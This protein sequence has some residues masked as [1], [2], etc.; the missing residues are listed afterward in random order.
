MSNINLIIEER[1][2][3]IGKFLVGR[4]LPF[5]QKRM[6]GPFIYLD[7]MGP[8]KLNEREHFD[9]L[10]HPH[11]G[12]STLTFL[13]EGSIMH[14]DTLG[15]EVEIKP[16]AV[17]WMTAGKGIVHSERTPEYLRHED[18]VMHGLQIW[19]ALPK[20]LEQMNPEFF[21]IEAEKLPTWSI[22]EVDYKLIAGE[23]MGHRST[24]P[25]YSNLFLMEIKSRKRQ[26]LNL[27]NHLFGESGLYIMEGG[28]ESEG[29]SY[30]SKQILVAKDSTLCTFTIEAN[31]T[32]YIFG[33]EPFPEERFI[34]WNFVSSSKE[35][36]EE[37]KQK[38][39]A[40]QFDKI[41]GDELEFVP[42]PTLKK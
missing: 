36:I 23:I 13:F 6:I 35:L 41:K 31:S 9:I 39:N 40:Q 32:I 19:V 42:Y 3:D 1:A 8:V 2:A 30:G 22:A 37:A 14:R 25:V 11:I 20:H 26:V 4:L 33:G 16:G 12:L 17:N 18:L 28:I 29:N 5:R 34:D 38:W 24:V 7:H 27:G 21:H 10:P 15:N